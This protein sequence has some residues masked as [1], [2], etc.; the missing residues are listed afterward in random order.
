MDDPDATR[1]F[2][3]SDRTEHD[4]AR[5]PGSKPAGSVSITAGRGAIR[6]FGRGSQ[7]LASLEYVVV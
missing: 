2:A 1:A 6:L 4:K 3:V 5:R 7:V